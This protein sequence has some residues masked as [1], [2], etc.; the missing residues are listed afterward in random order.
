MMIGYARVSRDDQNL[1][2]QR[3]ALRRE[4]CEK[5]FAEKVSGVQA[6][7]PKLRA[8]LRSLKSGDVLVV[9]KID[10]LARSLRDLIDI[11]EDLNSRG[12]Q[13]KSS[14]D[15]IDTSTA[16]GKLVFHILGAIAEFERSLISER[17]REGMRA[18]ARRGKH[19]GRPR[20]AEKARKINRAS[21]GSARGSSH[22]Q[23]NM[24]RYSRPQ[25]S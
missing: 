4:G 24:R 1:G 14:S 23:S 12:C 18:A 11:V 10:R 15:K 2:L 5:V 3:D 6:D 22:D 9:W 16:I 13:F 8:A 25:S 7:R 21:S 20:Q 17:T 19:V